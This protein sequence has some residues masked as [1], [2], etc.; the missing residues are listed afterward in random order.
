MKYMALQ[1]AM[2]SGRVKNNNLRKLDLHLCALSGS[3]S[4]SESFHTFNDSLT[5]SSLPILDDHII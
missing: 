4:V 1:P 3:Q 5:L 2:Q